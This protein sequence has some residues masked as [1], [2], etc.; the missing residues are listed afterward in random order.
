MRGR[1]RNAEIEGS[2]EKPPAGF[3]T[4]RQ[5]LKKVASKKLKPKKGI[6]PPAFYFTQYIN[7]ELLASKKLKRNKKSKVLRSLKYEI[8]KEIGPGVITGGADNDPAGIVTY[9]T[10]GALYGYALLWVLFICTPLMIVIQEMASRLALVKKKGLSTII[11]EHYG[12]R[13]ATITMLLLSIVNIATIGA[14]IAGMA[15]VLG[16]SLIHI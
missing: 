14:D 10:V 12:K 8:K 16:L 1:L 6:P 4:S 5:P 15:A 3:S 2:N 11:K 7:M 9:T 13:T